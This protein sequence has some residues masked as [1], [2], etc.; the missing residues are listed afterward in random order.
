M[1]AI[2]L[3][4]F[5]IVGFSVEREEPMYEQSVRRAFYE[6]VLEVS[7]TLQPQERQLIARGIT[8]RDWVLSRVFI[9][10]GRK[11]RVC[12]ARVYEPSQPR[13]YRVGISRHLASCGLVLCRRF[14]ILKSFVMEATAY[15]PYRSGGGTGTG[16][17]ATGL[18][19]GY[20]L[21]AVDPRVALFGTVLYVEGYGLAIAADRGGAIRGHKID[22]CFATRQQAIRFGRRKVRVFILQGVVSRE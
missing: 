5:A 13:V 6:V 20:G 11:H 7:S 21:V 18:P 10:G 22:L 15:T 19:A 8:G 4:L 12:Y 9:A 3:C 2:F 16:R 1:R 14:R 17:T